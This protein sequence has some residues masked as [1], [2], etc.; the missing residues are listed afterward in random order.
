M[1]TDPA[2]AP[3]VAAP[4]GISPAVFAR[5]A[6]LAARACEG[7]N[8]A[9]DALHVARVARLASHLARAEGADET[10]CVLAALLHE[11]VNL[12]KHHPD[13]A[14]SGDL[15]AVEVERSLAAEGVEAH[16]VARVVACVRDHAFSKG[17]LPEAL[18]ARV[19]QDADRLDALGAVGVAR[20]MATCAETG[21]PFYRADDPLCV[22]RTPDDKRWGL[23][24]F[25]RKL[26]KLPAGMH[27]ATARAMAA[28]RAAF[29]ELFLTQFARELGAL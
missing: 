8:P 25:Y 27:T 15:C 20:C 2:L 9:H 4:P 28:E 14:R 10:V 18:E 16:L 17:A 13:S 5:L 12:P 3:P 22:S 23:D 24:H 21:T 26:L 29:C 1:S 19:L 7:R 11:L 6:A